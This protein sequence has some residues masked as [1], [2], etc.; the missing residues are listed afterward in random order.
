[1]SATSGDDLGTLEGQFPFRVK[2]SPWM[3]AACLG[4]GVAGLLVG[5]GFLGLGPGRPGPNDR[6]MTRHLGFFLGGILLLLGLGLIVMAWVVGGWRLLVFSRG[7][8]LD[9]RGRRESFRWEDL[10][11]VSGT[12]S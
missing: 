9:K 6:E 11:T 3:L 12:S 10:T 4:I 1:M 8:S 5:F 2:H 7:L